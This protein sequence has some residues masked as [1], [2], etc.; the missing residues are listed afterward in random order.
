[1]EPV[2]GVQSWSA[3]HGEDLSGIQ[4]HYSYPISKRPS[5]FHA[6]VFKGRGLGSPRVPAAAGERLEERHPGLQAA[7]AG[8]QVCGPAL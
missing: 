6:R 7:G 4:R 1:M 3:Q 2:S 5:M 8:G